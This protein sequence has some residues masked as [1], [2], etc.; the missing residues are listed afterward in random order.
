MF[1]WFE[2][3]ESL[4]SCSN[5]FIVLPS[6]CWILCLL[7]TCLIFSF[8]THVAILIVYC[9]FR[10]I[11][12]RRSDFC[13]FPLKNVD[14][15]SKKKTV[16]F[17]IPNSAYS[18]MGIKWNLQHL[19][20]SIFCFP[21]GLLKSSPYKWSS[22]VS[23]VFEWLFSWRFWGLPFSKLS[24]FHKTLPQISSHSSSPRFC[25]SISKTC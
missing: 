17:Q 9:K 23:Q 14:F 20:P 22:R 21:S 18:A 16:L 5:I 7:S 3:S 19:Q 11:P 24:P 2:V 13:S 12:C 4:D 8:S 25:P 10:M 1:I 6:P 15:C